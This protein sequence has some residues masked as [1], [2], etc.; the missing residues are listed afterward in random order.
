MF[1][2]DDFGT[3]KFNTFVILGTFSQ[4]GMSISVS[5]DAETDAPLGL[6]RTVPIDIFCE[7]K[8]GI[9]TTQVSYSSNQLKKII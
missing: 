4:T 7:N 3:F 6:E 9:E 2:L 8:K 1:I 5:Q